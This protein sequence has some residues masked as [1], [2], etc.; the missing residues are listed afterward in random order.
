MNED[1]AA[2]YH[3]LQRRTAVLSLGVSTA[4]LAVL[5]FSGGSV[6]LRQ[7]AE[8]GADRLLGSS[9]PAVVIAIYV[10]ALL[11]LHE[12][13]AFPLSLYRSFLVER[14]Y[15]LSRQQLRGWVADHA[16]GV[17]LALLFGVA[18]A[19]AAY[20]AMRAW[21]GGWWLVTAALFVGTSILVTHL[22]PVVLFPLFYRFKPLD[23]EALH[24]R[25]VRLAE[26]ARSR[27]LGVYEWQLGEKSTRANAALIGLR[28]TRRIVLSDTLLADYTEDEIEVILAHE[29]AH[30]MHRDIWKGLAFDAALVVAG[31]ALADLALTSLAPV[32]G[33]RGKADVA[34]LPSLLLVTGGVSVVLVPL[35]N[36]LS[37]AHERRADLYALE[38]TRNPAAFVSAMRRLAAQNLAEPN[39]SRLTELL[40]HSHP[41][42]AERVAA[43]RRWAERNAA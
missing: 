41:P 28:G 5:A 29:L 12:L 18:A 21:P 27:V 20:A 10:V 30:H 40:F 36:A 39:P 23:R 32:L 34:S 26:R 19:E 33:W 4:L 8:T 42:V 25:L 43:A 22:A 9:A 15:G 2:R 3:R 24:R 1:K 14:R 35:A 38:T 17:A 37:R 31:L 16:K 6:A 11:A 7:L 13:L